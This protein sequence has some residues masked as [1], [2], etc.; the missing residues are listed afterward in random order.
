MARKDIYK[1]DNYFIAIGYTLFFLGAL[2][3]LLDPHRWSEIVIKETV[4]GTTRHTFEDKNGR[5]LDAIQKEKGERFVVAEIKREFPTLRAIMAVNGLVLLLIGY[6]YRSRERKIISV[7]HALEHTGEA[8]VSGLAV[9]LGLSREFILRHLKD[10]N[11]QQHSAYTYD[12]RS[13]KIINARLA[14]EYLVFVDC[15]NCGRKINQKVSLD[16][17]SP[18]QCEYCGTSVSAE[19]LNQLKQ[20]ELASMRSAATAPAAAGPAQTEGI[21]IVLLVVLI[22]FFWPAAVFYV[23]K[24]KSAA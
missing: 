12:S 5:A 17:S 21:N 24:K 4:D 2:S 14:S 13:D 7:W 18:P 8:A 16:L 22:I 23:V 15:A 1:I 6:G 11:A 3:I 10:I 20:D 9:S 19:H